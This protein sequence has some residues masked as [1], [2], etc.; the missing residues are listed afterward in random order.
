M[1]DPA[2]TPFNVGKAILLDNL[3]LE[4][5]KPLESGLQNLGVEPKTLLSHVLFWS[6]GQPYLTQVLCEDLV[7]NEKILDPAQALE[8]SVH[9]LFLSPGKLNEEANLSNVQRRIEE[10]S[11]VQAQMLS[12][13][14]EILEKGSVALDLRKQEQ[15]YLKLS[16]LAKSEAGELKVNNQ[17][18]Q[19][20]FDRDW[21]TQTWDKLQRPFTL[22][23]RNWEA[24]NLNP[25]FLLRGEALKRGIEWASGRNDLNIREQQFLE[26][27]RK[28]KEERKDRD[29]NR[30]RYAILVVSFLAMGILGIAYY[31]YTLKLEA[32][33]QRDNTK[34]Q[35][36]LSDSLRGIAEL[37][38]DSLVGTVSDLEKLRVA[39]QV[40]LD[41][42]RDASRREEIGRLFAINQASKAKNLADS[43]DE[44]GE[45][46]RINNLVEQLGSK[47]P[48]LAMKL[49]EYALKK[50]PSPII[51]TTLHD[52]YKMGSHYKLL[53][54]IDQ[55][56][57]G[58]LEFSPSGSFLLTGYGHKI[59]LWDIVKNKEI[60]RFEGHTSEILSLVF[61]PNKRQIL[62]T[63]E[64]GSVR[65]WNISSG[66]EVRRFEGYNDKILSLA[67]HPNGK[68]VL[69]ISN[70]KLVIIWDIHSGK[71]IQ[72]LDYLQRINNR[73]Q[74]VV[75]HPNCRQNLCKYISKLCTDL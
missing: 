60:Q 54:N 31:A 23:I 27:S 37:A 9:K 8:E 35:M 15:L 75:F 52:Q 39:L 10:T 32:D 51:R 22:E 40:A 19:E 30:L 46:L 4:D 5:T 61:L 53:A 41:T 64:N 17:I 44:I 7:Q 55:S 33:N 38:R 58:V 29:Q 43:L 36:V 20:I 25:N 71:E 13:Y 1:D 59:Q 18:Y 48:S 70:T 65:L 26:A 69:G 21:L 12:C 42:T 57:L 50:F 68:Q 6:G 62:T 67:L 45:A 74:T 66:K 3:K 73:F 47:N 14:G 24:N 63:S 11:P 72:R 28:A 16:G 2:R 56:K 34:K 49:A